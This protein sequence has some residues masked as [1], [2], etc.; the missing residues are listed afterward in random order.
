MVRCSSTEP[1]PMVQ[2]MSGMANGDAAKAAA[3]SSM[4]ASRSAVAVALGVVLDQPRTP[5]K[6]VRWVTCAVTVTSPV[7]R[8]QGLTGVLPVS[9]VVLLDVVL[10][11]VEVLLDVLVVLLLDVL[12]LDVVLVL[13][14]DELDELDDVLGG[15]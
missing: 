15:T 8:T 7:K 11:L 2:A 12:L 5:R 9:L 6:K 10:L 14:L 1:A 13:L 4:T 3:D